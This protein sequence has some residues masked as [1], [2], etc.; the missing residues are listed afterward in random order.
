MNQLDIFYNGYSYLQ[1]HP[2]MG[3][4]GHLSGKQSFFSQNG[5]SCSDRASQDKESGAITTVFS[6]EQNLEIQKINKIRTKFFQMKKNVLMSFR[7][8]GIRSEVFFYCQDVQRRSFSI[9]MIVVFI[10]AMGTMD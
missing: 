9:R 10:I 6:I 4:H 7:T 2:S 1:K 3:V 8:F 5:Y